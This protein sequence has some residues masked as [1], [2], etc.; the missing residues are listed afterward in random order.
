MEKQT[1][2]KVFAHANP[3]RTSELG[4]L[5][6]SSS[7]LSLD[8]LFETLRQ[9]QGRGAIIG[10]YG[11]G[12]TTLLRLFSKAWEA[13]GRK[14]RWLDVWDDRR[15]S[16]TELLEFLRQCADADAII[17]D[18]ADYLSTIQWHCLKW[19][20]RRS[21]SLLISAHSAQKL[22]T[23]CHCWSSPALLHRI[24]QAK[25][26]KATPDLSARLWKKHKG[27]LHSA[28]AEAY[29]ICAMGG[30]FSTD[31]MGLETTA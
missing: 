16:W 28:L 14:V 15:L 18:G 5:L 8:M 10:D 17:I 9:R 22:S 2:V 19:K 20:R 23:L 1:R 7:A 31:K 27:N 26:P 11:T 4:N 29:D 12:K 3:F 21:E 13:R 24:I 30:D 25:I 6:F